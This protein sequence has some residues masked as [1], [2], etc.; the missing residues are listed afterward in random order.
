MRRRGARLAFIFSA[1]A[2]LAACEVG[3]DFTPPAAPKVARY[4]P[5]PLA[6]KTAQAEVHAGEG[7][8]FADGLDIPGEWWTLFR[9]EPL[10]RLIADALKANP[11]LA[12]AQAALR[13]AREN[14]YA[15][16][17]SLF[18]SI[19]V[20]A[21]ATE[22]VASGATTDV[23]GVTPP[24]GVTTATLNVAYA[25]DVFGGLRR[26]IESLEAQEELE[27]FQLEAAYL[28]LTANVVVAA[29]NE[30]SLRAQIAATQEI[31]EIETRELD[32]LK[33]QLELGGASKAAV[34]AQ[35]ATRAQAQASLPPLARTLAQARN[36]LAALAGRFPSEETVAKFE[37]AT[38]HLPEELPLSLPSKL[39]EQRPDVRAAEAELHEASANVGVATANQLPQFSITGQLGRSSLGFAQ[40]FSP[41]SGIWSIGGSV[42][43]TVFDAGTL[44]H[45]KRAAVA[46]YEEAEAQYR[47]TVLVAFQNVADALRALQ[48]D[49]D[50]VKAQAEAVRSASDSLAISREQYQAGAITYTALLNAEQTYQQARLGLVVA[51]ASRFA[52]TAALLQALGGGWWNRTDVA[53]AKDG[54]ERFWLPPVPFGSD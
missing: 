49:A 25:P 20:G 22:A 10:D 32:V 54:A 35:E 52:D 16:R 44:L 46:A 3:P 47:S 7:Q 6:A 18:P 42:A 43:Q 53:A 27:R 19:N 50:A 1:L 41:E 29:I 28:S 36:Q 37:L 45:K 9:S 5:E 12:A 24:F 39:V 14:V 33:K 17:G 26:Q 40:F 2:L 4:T 8:R 15:E 31:I 11:T 38:L 23:K 13:E 48:A 51:Q 30:A 21:S 34:L